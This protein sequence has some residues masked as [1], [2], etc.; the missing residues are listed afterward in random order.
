MLKVYVARYFQN[1]DIP[2]LFTRR[3]VMSKFDIKFYF[4][5][6]FDIFFIVVLLEYRNDP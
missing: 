3:I 5:N 1:L 4:L 6:V 2:V